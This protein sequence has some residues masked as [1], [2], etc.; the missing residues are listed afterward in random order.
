MIIINTNT[1]TNEQYNEVQNLIEPG[2]PTFLEAEMNYYKEFPCFYFLYEDKKLSAF[3]SVFIPHEDECEIYAYTD[4]SC[5][6][7]GYFSQL[8]I[9]A[10]KN[11]RKY[12]FENILLVSE[13][14]DNKK[15]A[16]LYSSDFI[17]KYNPESHKEPE[18]KLILKKNLEQNVIKFETYKNNQLIGRSKCAS[19]GKSHMIYEFEVLEEERGKGY[20][21]ETL[22]LILKDLTNSGITD[23]ILH[24]YGE[25]SVAKNLYFE[26][27]FYISRQIDYWRLS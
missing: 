26:N 4:P 6:K 19:T 15:L 13:N 2:T 14:R 1:L 21:K 20:G 9:K 27:G 8:L 11:L 22:L 3:L 7:K 12:K 25:N 24:I 5:R 16:E 17:L 18:N 10:L 23:I